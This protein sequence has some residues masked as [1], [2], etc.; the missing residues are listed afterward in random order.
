MLSLSELGID[1]YQQKIPKFIAI[2]GPIGVGKTTLANHLAKTFNAELWLERP[3]NNPFLERFYHNMSDYA[4]ATQ[5]SFLLDRKRQLSRFNEIDLFCDVQI[6]DFFI[7]KDPIFAETI[8]KPDELELYKMVYEQL[9]PEFPTPDL[10]IYLQSSV[11]K[12]LKQI[13]KRGI[14]SERKI[15]FEYLQA[16]SDS[17]RNHFLYY[18]KSP[19]LVLNIDDLDFINNTEHY[20]LI[21]NAILQ[22]KQG[23]KYIHLNQNVV[24]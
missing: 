6:S 22:H 11:D 24:I 4:L 16:L 14:K 3:E 7:D 2:E 17:Y 23:A 13:N 18:T 9:A 19:M 5:L 20:K 12:L 1:T 10:L 21:V 15:D 8:L